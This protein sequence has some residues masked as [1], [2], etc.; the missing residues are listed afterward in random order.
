MGIFRMGQ[1]LIGVETCRLG[2]TQIQRVPTFPAVMNDG[3]LL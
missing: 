3:N 2:I 1:I